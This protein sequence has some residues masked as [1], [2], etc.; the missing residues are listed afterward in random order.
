MHWPKYQLHMR[1]LSARSDKPARCAPQED[2]GAFLGDEMKAEEAI[3]EWQE[4]YQ[5]YKLMEAHLSSRKDAL[6]AK[7]PQIQETL[8][9]VNFMI[10]KKV[11]SCRTHPHYADGDPQAHRLPAMH[12]RLASQCPRISSWRMRYSPT[13]S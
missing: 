7:I 10:K 4:R 3:R 8:N 1:G 5:K 13:L 9:M 6:K 2:V 12:R 11:W